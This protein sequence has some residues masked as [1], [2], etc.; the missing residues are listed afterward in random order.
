M[1]EELIGL[2][3]D[4]I[5]EG[6][7]ADIALARKVSEATSGTSGETFLFVAGTLLA[8]I[9]LLAQEAVTSAARPG[10]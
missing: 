8:I 7:A 6:L 4:E 3:E 5:I 10:R 1:P 2:S 9:L